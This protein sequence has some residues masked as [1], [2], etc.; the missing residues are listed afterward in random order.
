MPGV[1]IYPYKEIET[2]AQIHESL[3][4]ES[5]R[6]PGSS[7]ATGSRARQRRPH[8]RDGR[9]AG[10]GAR[11]GAEARGA[12]GREPRLAGACRM[13]K[14]A[15]ISGLNSTGVDVADLRVS[16]PA[17]SR[18]VLKTQGFAAAIHVGAASLDPEVVQIRIFEPPG[19]QLTAALEKEIE[20]HFTR[21]ELRRVGFDE[22]GAVSYPARV[23]ESYAQDILDHLDCDAIRERGFRIVVDLGYSAASFVL[24][25]VVG[26]MGV[27]TVTT[28]GFFTDSARATAG[29]RRPSATRSG[30]SPPS[31]PTSAPSSTARRSGSCS[32]TRR[33][34]RSPS[35]RR[36]CSSCGCSPTA[37]Q[38][39]GGGAGDRDP[40]GRRGRRGQRARGGADAGVARRAHACSGGGRHRLRRAPSS[41]GYV[42]PE[43]T[44][45][46]DAVATL[47][48]LL[49]LLAPTGRSLSEHRRRAAA[50]DARAPRARLPVVAEGARHARAQR[51]AAGAA[52]DLLDGIKVFD[53]RGWSLV[54][55]DPDEPLVHLYAEGATADDSEALAAELQTLVEE[56]M[57]GDEA[58]TANPGGSLKLRLTLRSAAALL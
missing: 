39:Q 17:I 48:K 34:T 18:H 7:T 36:C 55:P 44:P 1:R 9:P 26:P 27:E 15:M 25:L 46:Y 58:R 2:G 14:R 35:S 8:S 42:F 6:P 4:W 22:I 3:I 21:Q 12:G 31:A 29:S 56:I 11:H 41:G 16:P 10:R 20:K 37:A 54:L 50:L 5:R 33:G 53:E 32:S 13:L 38:R 52:L 24:P 30:S 28:H 40:A 43:F 45:A 19:I 23:R 47:C 51:A 49:E 57:E